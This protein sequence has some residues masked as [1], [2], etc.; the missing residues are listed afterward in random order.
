MALLTA[1]LLSEGVQVHPYNNAACH[2]PGAAAAKGFIELHRPLAA[3]SAD[4][5]FSSRH[6]Q[7][8][9]FTHCKPHRHLRLCWNS[10]L[11][12]TNTIAVSQTR[13]QGASREQPAGLWRTLQHARF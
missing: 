4:S 8:G 2:E 13:Q 7:P 9:E 3:I 12:L 5:G 6:H 10:P 1:L 11:D